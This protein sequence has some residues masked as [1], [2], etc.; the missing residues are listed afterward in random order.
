[1]AETQQ[2]QAAAAAHPPAGSKDIPSFLPLTFDPNLLGPPGASHQTAARQQQTQQHFGSMGRQ[3]PG[4]MAQGPP[5]VLGPLPPYQPHLQQQMA[6][7]FGGMPPGQ[8]GMPPVPPSLMHPQRMQ[9]L[10]PG[11]PMPPVPPEAAGPGWPGA[12]GGLP[13]LPPGDPYDPLGAAN[14]AMYQSAANKRR[15]RDAPPLDAEAQLLLLGFLSAVVDDS[16][17]LNQCLISAVGLEAQQEQQRRAAAAAGIAAAMPPPPKL[18]VLGSYKLAQKLAAE[19][20]ARPAI[21]LVYQLQLTLD[22]ARRCAPCTSHSAAQRS[23]RK[24]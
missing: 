19:L 1:M 7:G 12:P 4:P 5:G 18:G 22:T 15:R 16:N 10:P 23:V 9:Q 6:G 11:M 13:P 24:Q 21:S 20:R 3:P 2:P 17:T 8:L 14:G